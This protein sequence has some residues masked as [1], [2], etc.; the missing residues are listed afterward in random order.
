VRPKAHYNALVNRLVRVDAAWTEE[1]GES[2]QIPFEC[3]S[4]SHDLQF[5]I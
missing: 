4:R 3:S 2:F 1:K 5:C